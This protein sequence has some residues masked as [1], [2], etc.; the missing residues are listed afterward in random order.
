MSISSK[1]SRPVYFINVPKLFDDNTFTNLSCKFIYNFYTTDE[2]TQENPIIPEVYKKPTISKND[3]SLSTFSLRVPRYVEI[4][5]KS[6]DAIQASPLASGVNP[7]LQKNL[8]KIVTQD[9]ILNSNFLPYNFESNSTLE[10]AVDDINKNAIGQLLTS[11]GISQATILENFIT[12]LMKDYEEVPEKPAILE[13]RKQIKVAID[14]LES[15]VDRSDDLLGYKFYNDKNDKIETSFD[16]VTNRNV[17]IYSQLNNSIAPDV[18]NLT[19]LS[20]ATLTQVN[21]SSMQSPN[22]SDLFISPVSIGEQTNDFPDTTNSIDIVGYIIDRYEFDGTSYIKNKTFFINDAKTTVA[23][24]LNVKYGAMY[25]YAIRAIAKIEI[26]SI[27]TESNTVNKCMYYCAGKPITTTITCQ[28]DISPP[29]PTELNFVWEYKIKKFHVTWQMPF[30][31]QRDIKQFQVFRRKSIY[32][33][34]ELLEQQCFD[35]SDIKQTTK[36]IIDGNDVQM[37]KEN[38]S[39]VKYF[40]FPTYDYLDEEFKVNFETL[41]SS[42]YIYAIASIDAHGLISNYSAQYEVSFDFYKNQLIKKLISVAD[43]PRPYPNLSLNSDL[44]KDVIQ[45][46]GLSSQKLKIYFMPEY[47]KLKYN[48]GKIEK[49]VTTK[50]DGSQGGYYKLQFINVQNQKSDQLKINIDDPGLLTSIE[51]Q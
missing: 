41:T 22:N 18:F 45:T 4:S 44:F 46:S 26:P 14:S 24:D 49:M 8:S 25:H 13:I 1:P 48:S 19:A 39:F 31:S 16:E 28:E 38:A 43:A 9:N 6:N 3:V 35:F 2:S 36:E 47:F 42:K 23:Y 40:K 33:P 34:F 50:Q 51:E 11:T 37:N 17:K 30:N 10:N 15:F 32:E 29:P 7:D 21:N 27:L 12:D 20:S 5:W